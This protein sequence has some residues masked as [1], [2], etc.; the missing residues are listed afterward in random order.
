MQ[1][2]LNDDA[3][4]A[5]QKRTATIER[6]NEIIPQNVDFISNNWIKEGIENS[7][8]SEIKQRGGAVW[9]SPDGDILF[10]PQ[11]T[12]KIVKLEKAKAQSIL[13][14]YLDRGSVRLLTGTKEVDPDIFP[15]ELLCVMDKFTPFAKSEFLE[16]DGIMYRTPWRPTEYMS[17][18]STSDKFEDIKILLQRLT[19]HNPTYYQWVINWL[20]GFLQT[21]KRSQCALVL[22]GDQGSGKGILFEHVITPLFGEEY[23]IVIDDDRLHS[24]FKNW[25]SGN[26]FYNLNE[27]SHDIKTRKA[28]KNFIKQLVTDTRVQAEQKYKDAGAIEIFGQVLITSNELA[29]LEIETSDRRFTIIQTDKALKK[30]GINTTKLIEDIKRQ[31]KAF[32]S[33]LLSYKVDWMQFDTALDT[34][35]KRA[36]V[37][38]TTDKVVLLGNAIKMRDISF[39]EPMEDTNVHLYNQVCDNLAKD[40]IIQSH[41]KIIYQDVF[42]EEVKPRY[43]LDKLKTFDVAIFGQIHQS[44]SNK[45]YK[46]GVLEKRF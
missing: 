30:D 17:P 7:T 15:N 16:I 8:L 25:I 37:N 38:A 43:L 35:E 34:P 24:N 28:V 11:Q 1:F 18:K 20:A 3:K 31:R 46:L 29:P 9:L 21:R 22:K 40:M 19:N 14:N 4:H 45:Y 33:F 36:V 44:G 23:C 5:V 2:T 6:P 32:A 13:A 41:I 27:I 42:G 39:F 10:R 12:A 26:L